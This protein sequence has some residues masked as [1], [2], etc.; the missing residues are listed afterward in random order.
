MAVVAGKYGRTVVDRNRLRRRLRELTRI[1]LLPECR[2]ADVV[3][4]A[5]P[6][7]YDMSFQE[8]EREMKELR[9]L[10]FGMG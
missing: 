7:A 1:Y 2:G 9:K 6:A 4:T 10:L 5:L 3:I 8:L